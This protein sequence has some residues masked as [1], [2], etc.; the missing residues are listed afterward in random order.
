MRK[1]N[2]GY[3][4]FLAA[5]TLAL[6]ASSDSASAITVLVKFVGGFCREEEKGTVLILTHRQL[7][8]LFQT[9]R[10]CG[11]MMPSPEAIG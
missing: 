11:E 1:N 7:F 3:T 9:R 4:F 8:E 2:E 5:K 6:L 10:A